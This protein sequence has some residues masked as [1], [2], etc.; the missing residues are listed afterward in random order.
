MNISSN[1]IFVSTRVASC[2]DDDVLLL[3]LDLVTSIPKCIGQPSP[4]VYLMEGTYHKRLFRGPSTND[5]KK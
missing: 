5:M 2:F 4:R 1:E 3:V